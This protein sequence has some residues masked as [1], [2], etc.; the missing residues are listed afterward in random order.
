MG[1]QRAP[2]GVFA[3]NSDAARAFADLW[4]RVRRAS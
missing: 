2:L 4:K 3:P 1:E